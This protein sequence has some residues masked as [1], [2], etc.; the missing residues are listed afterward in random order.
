VVRF[1][2][3]V[4]GW[5]ALSFGLFV[6][7]KL[8]FRARVFQLKSTVV[9]QEIEKSSEDANLEVNRSRRNLAG[10]SLAEFGAAFDLLMVDISAGNGFDMMSAA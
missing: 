5:L 10:M 7:E 3:S 2:L 9:N 1:F 6:F 8:E 4:S